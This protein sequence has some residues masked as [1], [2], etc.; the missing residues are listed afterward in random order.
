MAKRAINEEIDY[1]L[2]TLERH[3]KGSATIEADTE[4]FNRGILMF[5]ARL[6]ARVTKLPE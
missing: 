5:A 2:R 3:E 4:G 6:R 1:L